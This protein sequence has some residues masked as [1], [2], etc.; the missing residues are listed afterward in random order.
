MCTC[1][2][3]CTCIYSTCKKNINRATLTLPYYPT[4][5]PYYPTLLPYYP[6]LLPYY[7]TLLP[8]YFTILPPYPAT[9]L[10]YPATLC[11]PKLLPFLHVLYLTTSTCTYMSRM[12]KVRD[13]NLHNHCSLKAQCSFNFN[14]LSNVA[15][16]LCVWLLLFLCSAT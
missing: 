2:C 11:Y 9:P 7:P 8:Y 1:T 3:I 6:T 13:G 14:P 10:P 5:L 16:E 4:L 15:S 12:I